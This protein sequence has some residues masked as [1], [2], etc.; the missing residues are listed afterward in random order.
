M[1]TKTKIS[2]KINKVKFVPV[3]EG[4]LN[5]LKLTNIFFVY[6]ILNY[7]YKK[8]AKFFNYNKIGQTEQKFHYYSDYYFG[9]MEGEPSVEYFDEYSRY[10][11]E[12]FRRMKNQ[13]AVLVGCVREEEYIIG[14]NIE[15]LEKTGKLFNDYR[16]VIF[17]NDSADKTLKILNQKSKDNNK[18][19]IISEKN[20]FS[21]FR[22]HGQKRMEIMAYC[23]NKYL[24]YTQKN[25]SYFDYMIVFDLDLYGGWSNQ[26]IANSI[27]QDNWDMM[28]ANGLE[29]GEYYDSFPLRIKNFEDR[30][31]TGGRQSD[32]NNWSVR[33]DKIKWIDAKKPK[34]LAGQELVPVYSCFSGLAMYKMEAIKDCRYG[35]EDCEHV[36]FHKQI[37]KRGH[38]R[39]FINP[40]MIAILA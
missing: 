26:G 6:Y 19:I 24:E 14:R 39:F 2:K 1:K 38:K 20:Q 16:I 21:R 34:L 27:G 13:R 35:F 33:R 37:Y 18:I 12:G 8:I 32:G 9:I 17:E 28:G 4:F 3:N 29:N 31:Y 22:G 23:R 30:C 11:K 7:I 10:V 5:F 40:S 36:S 25:F 15:R